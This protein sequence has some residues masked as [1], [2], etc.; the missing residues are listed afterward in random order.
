MEELK[1][2]A[3]ASRIDTAKAAKNNMK[4]KIALPV[5]WRQLSRNTV[6]MEF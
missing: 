4:N 3:L 6:Q 1:I 5:F 2:A